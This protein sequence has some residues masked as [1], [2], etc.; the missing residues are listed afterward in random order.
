MNDGVL[1]LILL[2]PPLILVLSLGIGSINR[3][4][5]AFREK[6]QEMLE[7]SEDS[8]D[9]VVALINKSSLA[10]HEVAA[11][12]LIIYLIVVVA[13]TDGEAVT[14]L[15]CFAYIFSFLY[16]VLKQYSGNQMDS[17]IGAVEHQLLQY[18]EE[19]RELM[20]D[21]LCGVMIKTGRMDYKNL[22]FL[23]MKAFG[24]PYA[25]DLMKESWSDDEPIIIEMAHRCHEDLTAK[26]EVVHPDQWRGF[27]ELIEDHI[28]WR[29]IA[30]EMVGEAEPDL[31]PRLVESNVAPAPLRKFLDLNWKLQQAGLEAYCIV[32]MKKG[33]TFKWGGLTFVRCPECNCI[34]PLE[35]PV[36]KVIG[37]IGGEGDWELKNGVL[38]VQLW[39]DKDKKARFA[40]VDKIEVLPMDNVDWSVAAVPGDPLQPGNEEEL[41]EIKFPEEIELRPNTR[42]IISRF[43]ATQNT[44]K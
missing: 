21:R 28:Y 18:E 42:E 26:M 40:E 36:K 2:G 1:V 31:L 29:M 15:M 30:K 27:D 22:A 41:P 43:G 20:H 8:D 39:N 10:L 7:F 24:S 14:V 25:L 33:T 4:M 23:R 17:K 16:L 13:M 19:G 5:R 34:Q 38:T 6:F 9:K 35:A 3:K 32:D 37:Q 11:P 44:V 12:F